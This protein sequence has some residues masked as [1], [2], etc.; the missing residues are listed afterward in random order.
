MVLHTW[1]DV[2]SG[3]FLAHSCG[4]DSLITCTKNHISVVGASTRAHYWTPAVN[5]LPRWHDSILKRCLVSV[6]IVPIHIPLNWLNWQNL[7]FFLC[8]RNLSFFQKT[9]RSW[10]RL[11]LRFWLRR[12]Q[13]LFIRIKIL[14]IWS[15]FLSCWIII[16]AKIWFLIHSHLIRRHRL[17]AHTNLGV[18]NRLD[19][20][21]IFIRS[22]SD[23]IY[24]KYMSN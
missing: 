8:P 15:R 10:F 13:V 9:T 3:L 11:F 2:V 24:I 22:L 20:W 1:P 23:S 17:N 4:A 12:H 21:H 18:L 6:F 16:V 14:R 19:A 5:S 7:V